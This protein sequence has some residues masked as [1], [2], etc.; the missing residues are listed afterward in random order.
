MYIHAGTAETP[1]TQTPDDTPGASSAPDSDSGL[2][3]SPRTQGGSVHT[4]QPGPGPQI[5]PARSGWVYAIRVAR[6]RT[7]ARVHARGVRTH[8]QNTRGASSPV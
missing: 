5:R 8:Y 3:N 7:P 4:A 2:D 1:R 6:A